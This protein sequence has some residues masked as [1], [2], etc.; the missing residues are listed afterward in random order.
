MG[1]GSRRPRSG[2]VWSSAGLVG[3]VSGIDA[4]RHKSL[5]LVHPEGF[6]TISQFLGQFRVRFGSD[7]FQDLYRD[8]VG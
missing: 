1:G 7:Q 2:H 5:E 3:P 8:V 6:A 4:E